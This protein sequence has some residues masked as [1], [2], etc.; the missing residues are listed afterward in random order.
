MNKKKQL[1]L[2]VAHKFETRHEVRKLELELEKNYNL[3]LEN[4]FYDTTRNDIEELDKIDLILDEK[5]KA[6][7]FKEYYKNRNTD[8]KSMDI[9]S[10]DLQMVAGCQGVI[11]FMESTNVGTPMEVF[12]NGFVMACIREAIYEYDNA[13]SPHEVIIEAIKNIPEY[14]EKAIHKGRYT[15]VITD[16]YYDHPWVKLLATHRFRS[17]QEFEEWLIKEGYKNE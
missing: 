7:A 8:T 6:A 11:A 4:P 9:V 12:F 3:K 1:I 10:G 16:K 13:L 2:Y 14:K 17:V 5:E 15:M